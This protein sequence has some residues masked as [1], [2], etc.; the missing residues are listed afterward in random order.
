MADDLVGVRYR[1]KFVI[2]IF[3][4]VLLI[5]GGLWLHGLCGV[6][7]VDRL[8]W[9]IGIPLTIVVIVYIV[10]AINL[11]DG[12]DGLASGLSSAALIIYGIGFFMYGQYLFAMIS[13]ATLGVLV[14]F[15]YYNVFGDVNKRKKIF[16]GDTGSLTIGLI[17]SFLSLELY[18]VS[19]LGCEVYGTNAFILAF[20][21]LLIP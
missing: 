18:R 3:C 1:A 11:I 12:I 21:P 20:S 17:L 5:A 16:M 7:F 6:L 8:V 9:W 10:N 2:Q 4:A 13:F 14:P 15:F 19:S